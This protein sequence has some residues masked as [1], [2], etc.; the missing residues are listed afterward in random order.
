MFPKK[1]IISLAMPVLVAISFN[2]RSDTIDGRVIDAGTGKGLAQAAV[3]LQVKSATDSGPTAI[4]AF[5]DS[6]GRYSIDTGAI[7]AKQTST[8]KAQILG[9]EQKGPTAE[10]V[11]VLVTT[12]NVNFAM[13]R[14]TNIANQVPDSAWL[15]SIPD[16]DAKH[17]TVMHC[18]SCHQFPTA[19]VKDY[20]RLIDAGPHAEGSVAQNRTWHEQARRDS[21]HAIVKYMRARAYD[22]FPEKTLYDLSKMDWKTIQAPEYSVFDEEDE[23]TISDF[24]SRYMPTQF[25]F[26][27]PDSYHY[28]APLAVTP[29]T[30]IR[31]YQL[32]SDSLVREATAIRGSKAIW[33]AD[34]HKNR[35]LKLDPESGHIQWFDVPFKTGTGPHTIMGD[36][37]GVIWTSLLESDQ[38]ARFDPSTSKW[39]L[40]SLRPSGMEA[41]NYFGG[42]AI[43]HDMSYGEKYELKRDKSGKIW[44]TLIGINKLATLNP[45]T[46]EVE[47]FDAP[48]VEGRTPLG[49]SLYTVLLSADGSCAW[50]SQ[51]MGYI[52]CFN[53]ETKK[54]DGLYK[55]PSGSG[56]RRLSIDGDDNLWAP[57]YGSGQILKYDAKTRKVKKLYDLPDRSA[58]PYALT[59][60]TH[61]KV[62]WVANANANV[63]YRFDPK[64]EKF[65]V[66]PLPRPNGLL[67]K[68]SVDDETG[69]LITSYGN[70]PQGTGPSMAVTIHVGD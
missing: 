25:D 59:W 62:I 65:S 16:S 11:D 1:K 43:V 41:K 21:W 69:D 35:I 66:I 20:I 6:D 67:R 46:G 40:F 64:S 7:P 37:N 47:Y 17:L 24:L 68:I 14:S 34:V 56:P 42:Q 52:G 30:V 8:L 5:T 33:G 51:L 4:T 48:R 2:A 39:T 57:Y 15:S 23:K 22:I 10:A 12:Q 44:L 70:I 9:W 50:F 18:A 45:D 13:E 32:P 38:F 3:T 26:M 58:A 28:G 55:P 53:T 29:K 27:S 36:Q 61:R 31:E 54:V 49:T 19:K 63:I 60:D